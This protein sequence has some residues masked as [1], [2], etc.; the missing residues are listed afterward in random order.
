MKKNKSC[1]FGMVFMFVF[2]L[3]LLCRSSVSEAAEQ[4]I[5]ISDMVM[6]YDHQRLVIKESAKTFG[7]DVANRD[8]EIFF[9]TGTVKKVKP[10]GSPSVDV[11]TTSSWDCYDYD[12]L[13]GVV[14]DLSKLNR[15]KDNY[16]L[17]HGDVSTQ[18]TVLMIPKV[19]SR[20]SAKYNVEHNQ[21]YYYDMT[22]RKSPKL[23]QGY[24]ENGLYCSEEFLEYRTAYSGWYTYGGLTID[25]EDLSVY[26]EKGATLFFRIGARPDE[27]V[28]EAH[29]NVSE[30]T[31]SSILMGSV[32]GEPVKYFKVRPFAGI[33]TKVTIPKRA[34]A[35]KVTI[36]YGKQRF[37]LVKG[38]EYRIVTDAGLNEWI[39]GD[40]AATSQL[41]LSELLT[42]YSNPAKTL[43][44]RLAKTTTRLASKV[45]RITL[46]EP[47]TLKIVSTQEGIAEVDIE[48]DDIYHNSVKIEGS[49]EEVMV[50]YVYN[51]Y[52]KVMTG[53]RFF[54]GTTDAYEVYISKNGEC[55]DAASTPVYTVQAR[56]AASKKEAET[57]ISTKYVSNGDKIYIR[58]KANVK[59]AQWSSRFAGFGIVQ[60]DPYKYAKWD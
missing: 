14:I 40:E 56:P 53:I 54:N 57:T 19:I 1:F 9:A 36:D 39:S 45:M 3:T 35:P 59:T 27:T 41:P 4:S 15:A 12:K 48:N 37:T 18:N 43:E 55:P 2:A 29:A 5:S 7:G 26:L 10:K 6:E 24:D 22:D 42:K 32:K 60:Y 13:K 11:M 52:T 25:L 46:S 23:I 17:V 50:G 38:A 47:D 8:K 28:L 51:R 49:D 58:K 33:E 20:V 44:V 21:M 16:I 30:P 34:S 31:E